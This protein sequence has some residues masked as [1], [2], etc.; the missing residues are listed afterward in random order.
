MNSDEI[1]FKDS[2]SNHSPLFFFSQPTMRG[3]TPFLTPLLVL[4]M[5][6]LMVTRNTLGA[7]DPRCSVEK[8]LPESVL[9]G[10]FA[11]AVDVT[12]GDVNLDGQADVVGVS[13]QPGNTLSV[14]LNQGV[15]DGGPIVFA[16]GVVLASD[17]TDAASVELGD[18]DGDGYL[19]AVVAVKGTDEILWFRNEYGIGGD[20]ARQPPLA[21]V[22]TWTDPVAAIFADLDNSGTLDLVGGWAS[23]VLVWWNNTGGGVFGPPNVIAISAGGLGGMVDV[24]VGYILGDDPDLDV[25]MIR[26]L[27]VSGRLTV[28]ENEL[29]TGGPWGPETFLPVPEGLEALWVGDLDGD[30]D[31]DMLTYLVDTGIVIW[32]WNDNGVFSSSNAFIALAEPGKITSIQVGDMDGDGNFDVVVSNTQGS[33]ASSISLLQV[34]DG[35]DPE[36]SVPFEQAYQPPVPLH[37]PVGGTRGLALADFNGDGRLDVAAAFED[38]GKISV[39]RS[40]QGSGAPG[41]TLSFSSVAT[42]VAPAVVEDGFVAYAC[43]IDGDLDNDVVFTS[44][45]GNAILWTRNGDGLGNFE[46]PSIISS[47]FT[48]AAAVVCLDADLDGD[49]DL[50][51]SSTITEE[52]AVFYNLDGRGTF[53]VPQT[54]PV[55]SAPISCGG[56]PVTLSDLNNDS[57]VDI[58]T[59]CVPAG[60][61]YAYSSGGTSLPWP[62]IVIDPEINAP[63]LSIATGLIN[64]DAYLDVFVSTGDTAPITDMAGLRWYMA[65]PD[66]SF[67][68]PLFIHTGKDAVSGALVDWDYDGYLD[69]VY[70]KQNTLSQIVFKPNMGTPPPGEGFGPGQGLF[71]ESVVVA[72]NLAPL[73][74]TARMIVSDLD[75]NG[76]LDI[77]LVSVWAD[78]S[79]ISVYSGGINGTTGP[80]VVVDQRHVSIGKFVYAWVADIDGDLDQD[81][82]VTSET[83]TLLVEWFSTLTRGPFFE[84]IP[85]R[86][87]M[88]HVGLP[89]QTVDRQ[90]MVAVTS[91]GLQSLS[92]CVTDTLVLEGGTEYSRC[93]VDAPVEVSKSFNLVGPA[94]VDCAHP[95]GTDP[96]GGVLF[97][98]L[99]GAR[100]VISSVDVVGTGTA[101]SSPF[102]AQGLRVEGLG[103]QLV[104]ANGSISEGEAVL[105]SSQPAVGGGRGGCLGAGG[106]GTLRVEGAVVERCIASDGG[107]GIGASDSGTKVFVSHS[108]VVDNVASG[109]GGGGLGVFDSAEMQVSDSVVARN[110]APFGSGG[111]ILSQ[112]ASFTS[113]GRVYVEENEA[114][115][116]GGVGAFPLIVP[117]SAATPSRMA[118]A[119]SVVDLPLGPVLD[120]SFSGS[121]DVVLG[122]QTVL[123]SN[124][125]VGYG[126]GVFVC[127]VWV[128]MDVTE[129]S[130][131]VG[132]R[133]FSASSQELALTCPPS[134][135]TGGV[136]GDGNAGWVMGTFFDGMF[137]VLNTL[138]WVERPPT[139]FM[140]GQEVSGLVSGK[141][142]FGTPVAFS[143]VLVTWE[144]VSDDAVVNDVLVFEDGRQRLWGSELSAAVTPVASVKVVSAAIEEGRVPAEVVVN[145][146]VGLVLERGGIVEQS[147][148]VLEGS[149]VMTACVDGFGGVVDAGDQT[150]VG[151]APCVEGFVSSGV[152]FN[153]CQPTPVCPSNA[154][155]INVT[156]SS[157]SS[158]SSSESGLQPCVCIPGTWTP[159]G[160]VDSPC[161]PCPVGGRCVGGTAVPVAGEGFF[162][163]DE[164]DTFVECPNA[165]ACIGQGQCREGYESRLCGEC[166]SGYYRL[167]GRCFKCRPG[168]AAVALIAILILSIGAVTALVLFNLSESLRYKFAAAAIGLQGLQMS[169]IYGRLSELEWGEFADVYFRVVSSLN[170]NLELTS[171]E[172]SV[173]G[174]DVWV[175]KWTLTMMLPVFAGAVIAVVC[176]VVW[177]IGW[178][179][180]GEAL[181]GAGRS[182]TQFLALMHLPLT[183]VAFSVFG[184]SRE[185]ATGRWILTDDP[186]RSCFN[187]AWWRGL[188]LPGLLASVGYGFVIPLGV[189]AILWMR[190]RELDEVAF[191]L[192]YGFLVAR[193]APDKWWYESCVMLR[194][195]A[196]VV[197]MTFFLSD[198]SRANAGVVALVF[199]LCHLIK[200]NPY[201]ERDHNVLAIVVLAATTAVLFS[202]TIQARTLRLLGVVSGILLTLVAIVVGNVRDIVRIL[203]TEKEAEKDEFFVE[204]VFHMDDEE[205][206][207]TGSI[208]PRVLDSKTSMASGGVELSDLGMTPVASVQVVD[209]GYVGVG[210]SAELEEGEDSMMMMSADSV[211]TPRGFNSVNSAGGSVFLDSAQ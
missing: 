4:T 72:D 142:V 186:S 193:F 199:A 95:G 19:D 175:L 180:Q 1:F 156:S 49:M 28:F 18:A 119:T 177:V 162:P 96:L 154:F 112:G 53:S 172:C 117:G 147:T 191:N 26:S 91:G 149:M 88:S 9:E 124:V 48:K 168:A 76:F 152:S 202:G 126:G 204:G 148:L 134:G 129:W 74:T 161:V 39:L 2:I 155:R 75:H 22:V 8:F 116:G 52:R 98:V 67:T 71:N 203:R 11:G 115:L 122:S 100:V 173:K 58:I 153:P 181:S 190:Q 20:F 109:S 196:L 36:T 31:D 144:F 163:T 111:G 64:E 29:P 128:G 6:V 85:R 44:N 174:V 68:G 55:P 179:T 133:L 169:A 139:T 33:P 211:A 103:S 201:L 73:A 62:Q 113:S 170:L 143:K 24:K 13:G 42:P 89:M 46:T 145:Y 138:E 194:S 200:T 185:S 210:G 43:D 110:R 127:G 87:E 209:V 198:N 166:S 17:L 157:S 146:R 70:I 132:N 14:F 158:S 188:F 50:F 77:V 183:S 90:T 137:G 197:C 205:S 159:S 176:G 164:V 23:G 12:V 16:A 206:G 187:D 37:P 182:L 151:C 108:Q 5:V 47:T 208:G 99:G 123:T 118:L 125:G 192:R 101:R 41:E 178:K 207:S 120:L 32:I 184:C 121:P 35:F 57:F 40:E 107:G 104:F 82:V 30:G 84:Y 131:N 80:G 15:G 160:T 61:L 59:A 65:N 97:R 171:P 45:A 7:E 106:E 54:L 92:W 27:P 21:D 86:V 93:F 60:P 66:G 38:E 167:R 105:L 135:V 83:A 56:G 78:E 81:I 114:V 25:M 94:R 141:D 150:L 34:I 140:P 3:R 51:V 102:G 69:A 189:S 195:L 130:N 10:G 136:L 165:R 63:V 79:Q